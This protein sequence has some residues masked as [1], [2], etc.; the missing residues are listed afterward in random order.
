MQCPIVQFRVVREGID[1]ADGHDGAFEGRHAV[2]S[3]AVTEKRKAQVVRQLVPR[4][5]TRSSGR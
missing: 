2:E 1:L 4:H 5:Q 3:T